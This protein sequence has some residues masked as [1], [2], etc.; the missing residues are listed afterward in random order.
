MIEQRTSRRI[1]SHLPAAI[2][3]NN[4]VYFAQLCNLSNCGA[5]LKTHIKY[6]LDQQV[7]LSIYLR[8]GKTTL[9]LTVP[10][11]VVRADANGIG[12][13]SQHLDVSML[14]RLEG[15]LSFHKGN[16]E[17]ITAELFHESCLSTGMETD[18]SLSPRYP[19]HAKSTATG[20]TIQSQR[21]LQRHIQ[22]P[23]CKNM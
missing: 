4:A 8:D 2:V 23:E 13:Y 18:K 10:S 1:D 12:I 11:K 14:I 19:L 9:S 21:S 22:H 5:Y 17:Q 6:Y 20:L 15:H 16:F 3:H 7:D